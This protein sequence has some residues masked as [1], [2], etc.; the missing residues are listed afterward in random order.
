MK[1]SV[2]EQI[3]AKCEEIDVEYKF[4]QKLAGTAGDPEWPDGD[5]DYAHFKGVADAHSDE[6][7]TLVA[8]LQA[9][10]GAT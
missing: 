4:I 7:A 9:L 3:R 1:L 6:L 2:V 8:A 5:A 10:T